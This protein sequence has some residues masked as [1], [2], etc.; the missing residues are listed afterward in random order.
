MKVEQIFTCHQVSEERKV[1]LV[2]LSFQ[3][4]AMYWWTSLVRDRRLH[5]DLPIQYWNELRNALRRR[6]IPSYYIR[7]LIN[8]LQRLHQKNMTVEKYRQ[9]MELYLMRDGI[10]EEENITIA[11]FLSGLTFEIR[12]KVEL[13]PCRDL[14]DLVQ[15]CINVEQQNLRKNFKPSSCSSPYSKVDYKKEGFRRKKFEHYFRNEISIHPRVSYNVR[16]TSI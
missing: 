4:H 2:T 6:H 13:L 9:T 15:L 12:D 8:K 11:R 16:N 7:E 5:N 3:G 1:P 14:N 10:R